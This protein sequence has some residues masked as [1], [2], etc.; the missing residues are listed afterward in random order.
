MEVPDLVS[1]VGWYRFGPSPGQA[2]SALIAGHVDDRTQGRGAFFGLSH[3]DPGE[4]VR[5]TLSND[6]L[7][8]FT[9]VARRAYPK[10]RLPA[11]VSESAGRPMLVLVTC[12]G[13]F[14]LATRHYADNVVVFAVPTGS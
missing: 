4:E 14:D 13:S 9:V 1:A 8:S 11:M 3:L 5:V 7:R 12:G 2:G 10:G 6:R